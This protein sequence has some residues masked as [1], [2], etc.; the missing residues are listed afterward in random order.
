MN[1]SEYRYWDAGILVSHQRQRKA[2][3]SGT[4]RKRLLPGETQTNL[5]IHLPST[6]STSPHTHSHPALQR[7]AYT[8][9]LATPTRTTPLEEV[10][11][12]AFDNT[13]YTS[14]S[15]P[16][17]S[18]P[19]DVRGQAQGLDKP[20]RFQPSHTRRVH[21]LYLPQRAHAETRHKREEERSLRHT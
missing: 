6:P 14:P 4:Q 8:S 16:V 11:T 13:A 9:E 1:I 21:Q 20:L 15:S 3:A 19:Q 17:I 7:D 2:G 10:R 12:S 5:H 18:V